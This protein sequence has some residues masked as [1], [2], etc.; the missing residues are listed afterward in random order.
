MPSSS[1][2]TIYDIPNQNT[3]Y[4]GIAVNKD[5]ASES[6]D[7]MVYTWSLFRGADGTNGTNG[8]DG[9]DGRIVYPAG[10]YDATVTY[11]ATD[12]KAP[13]VLYGDT[14]YIMN[15]TTSWTGSQND[16]KT[17]ADDYEQYGE[18]ATWIPMEK[19]EAIYTKLLIADNGTLG[20]FVFNGDYMF[21]Q[22]G[23]DYL[24]NDTNKY[25]DFGNTQTNVNF[26]DTSIWL[27]PLAGASVSNNILSI[28]ST[29]GLY[30]QD[31]NVLSASYLQAGVIK[32]GFYVEVDGIEEG[33]TTYLSWIYIDADTGSTK[34]I[35]MQKSGVFKL[36]RFKGGDNINRFT[37]SCQSALSGVNITVKPLPDTF[38]PN[39]QL[40][41]NS[42]DVIINKG[43]I[44]ANVRKKWNIMVTDNT[45][46]EALQIT[47]PDSSTI[48]IQG[49]GV[50]NIV[51]LRGAIPDFYQFAENVGSVLTTLS[52]YNYSSNIL[53]FSDVM[54][55][56][57]PSYLFPAGK[58]YDSV[59]VRQ[60][61][62]L[63]VM[64]VYSG[65][66]NMIDYIVMNA[67]DFEIS[68]E[69]SSSGAPT[70]KKIAS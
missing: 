20:K 54:G 13:Y 6:T 45:D 29:N 61:G 1:S 57:F 36:P 64:V 5:T 14:Y 32:D 49:N 7:A 26:G 68:T 48:F 53:H 17:P 35:Y 70:S 38:I 24:G 28:T 37:L 4:I 11:T 56:Y 34:T 19:F 62:R 58:Q 59:Y 60:Y 25:E 9:R 65:L 15:V 51:R 47:E 52:F 8:K 3:K 46:N 2:S 31:M 63:E 41:G 66:F 40:D 67:S 50:K 27:C 10:I 30:G 12:T 55:R 33:T 44:T 69:F 42:G 23:T 16:G 21:S 43:V 39:L 18:H 22:M